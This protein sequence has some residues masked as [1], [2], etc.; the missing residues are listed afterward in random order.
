MKI[1]ST[2]I[3][4]P[5]LFDFFGSFLKVEKTIKIKKNYL[6]KVPTE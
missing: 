1:L 4:L 2:E 5:L 6:F 3:Y